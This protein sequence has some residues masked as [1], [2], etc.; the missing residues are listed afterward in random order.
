MHSLIIYG[1]R[2]I[3]GVELRYWTSAKKGRN[4]RRLLRN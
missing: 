2:S 1:I 3:N 4:F